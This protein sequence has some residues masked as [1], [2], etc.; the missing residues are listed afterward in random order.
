MSKSRLLMI[1]VVIMLCGS[2]AQACTTATKDQVTRVLRQSIKLNE[3][4]KKSVQGSN[5]SEYQRLRKEAERY[6]ES[7]AIPCLKRAVILLHQTPNASLVKVLFAHAVSNENSADETESEVLATLFVR[8]GQAFT[9]AWGKSST[10]TRAAVADR[11]R[12]GWEL[13]KVRYA[14]PVRQQVEQRIKRIAMN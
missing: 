14:L 11:I 1:F 8:H 2:I 7:T 4:F 9:A 13:I 6:K 12:S 10:N 3:A 5:D